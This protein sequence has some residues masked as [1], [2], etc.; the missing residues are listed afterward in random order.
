VKKAVGESKK[1]GGT[2]RLLNLFLLP[3]AVASWAVVGPL[4]QTLHELPM[5]RFGAALLLFL[6]PGYVIYE[7]WFSQAFGGAGAIPASFAFSVSLFGVLGVPFLILHESL[8]AYLT[9]CGGVVA[10]SLAV[11]LL[12]T[13]LGRHRPEPAQ[14]RPEEDISGA[15]RWLWVPL[16]GGAAVLGYVA[17]LRYPMVD[18][19]TWDYLAWIREYLNTPHL[20]LYDPYFGE[21]IAAISRVKINGWLLE[22]AALSRVAGIDPVTLVLHYLEPT[23]V[24]VALLAFYALGVTL[25]GSPRTALLAATLYVLFLLGHL[26]PTPQSLGGE[27]VA[28]VVQDKFLTRYLFLPVALALAL[29]FVRT[30]RARYLLGFAFLCWAVVT[31]HPV[32][33]AVIAISV[34]GFGIV[35]LLYGLRER[36][37]WLETAGLAL[38]FASIAI[39]PLLYAIFKGIPPT[40]KLYDA[41]I[42]G[43]PPEVLANMVFVRP[44]WRHIF[45]LGD[46]LYIMHP[47]LLLVPAIALGYI[48]GVPFLVLRLR[49]SLPARLLLG[50]LAVSTLVCYL[51]PLAT[52][53]GNE[54]IAPGQLYRMAWPIPLATVMTDAWM[55]A[56][57]VRRLADSLTRRGLRGISSGLLAL[58]FVIVLAGFAAPQASSGIRALDDGPPPL[59]RSFFFDPIFRWMGTHIRRPAVIMAPDHDNIAIPA[60]SAH[61]NVVSFRGDPILEHLDQL[62]KLSDD[63]I[64]VPQRD[65][66]VHKFYSGPT[67]LEAYKILR[68]YHVQYVLVYTQTPLNGQL[69]HLPGFVHIPTPSQRY[70][71]FKVDY[72]EFARYIGIRPPAG[73][74]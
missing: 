54:V 57:L 16:A 33:L 66:D 45:R 14:R 40:A 8:S 30:R 35:H 23:L 61:L 69:M 18:G 12:G 48:A 50:T 28:R 43:T 3:L 62:E 9:L 74:S 63:R 6:I 32:G 38:P 68:R 67:M 15:A 17:Q 4:Q 21:R 44:E 56:V 7:R 70:S 26:E 53:V 51:P 27:I 37:A 55:A 22:Q 13:I 25:F 24:V 58:V 73:G 1:H 59:D 20:A 36:R 39:G 46:G 65:L 10:L 49:R 64:K 5:L 11:S 41:D 72:Q 42:G 19:D 2:W 31:V 34:G 29:W 60:Y 52:F 47:Y 71:L